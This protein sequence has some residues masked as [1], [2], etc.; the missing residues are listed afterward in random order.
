MTVCRASQNPAYVLDSISRSLVSEVRVRVTGGRV[1]LNLSTILFA[2][3]FSG[4]AEMAG[5]YV[6]AFAR[7]YSAAVQLV[8]VIDISVAY[9]APDAGMSI[10]LVRRG[11]EENLGE[12][13]GQ[14][15]AAGVSCQAT[16]CEGMETAKRILQIAE[17]K[18]ADLIVTGTRGHTGLPW[19]ALGSTAEWL[20]HHAECPVVT[21]GPEVVP[22]ADGCL[23]HSIV[24]ATDFT[25]EAARAAPFAFSLA[26]DSGLMSISVMYFKI[27]MD[28]V[29]T[30]QRS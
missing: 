4:I 19:L 23:F 15:L 28:Q 6:K 24:Y 25:P 20:I 10:D 22:P 17:E 12:V 29:I 5:R 27:R 9:R 18:S 21:I 7:R 30:R 3:D 16:L 26:K 2:T 1:A 11:R 13:K 14:F 8:H